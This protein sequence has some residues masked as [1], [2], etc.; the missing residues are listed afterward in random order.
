[1]FDLERLE[2]SRVLD[3]HPDRYDKVN[4]AGDRIASLDGPQFA[5]DR[6]ESDEGHV[7]ELVEA[8]GHAW[9]S[10]DCDGYQY[11]AGPCSHLCG[12]WRAEHRGLVEIP[13]ANPTAISA[14]VRDGQQELAD[15]VAEADA[16]TATDGGVRR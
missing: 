1:M 15:Q 13:T 9:G 16:R 2:F 7:C 11:N 8:F 4:L 3:T 6:A 12:V 10:C 5:V 14:E